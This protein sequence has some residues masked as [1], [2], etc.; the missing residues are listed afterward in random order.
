MDI[1][2]KCVDCH[3]EYDAIEIRYM[4]ECGGTLEV[5][6]DLDSLKKLNLLKLFDSRWGSRIKP[7][8]SGVWRYKESSCLWRMSRS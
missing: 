8:D 4:C 6:H 7:Y 3:K 2:L 1:K 5:I